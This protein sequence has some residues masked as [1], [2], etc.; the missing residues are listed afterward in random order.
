MQ[1]DRMIQ[2]EKHYTF[3][4]MKYE[5]ISQDVKGR[6]FT[7]V[8]PWLSKLIKTHMKFKKKDTCYND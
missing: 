6:M 2:K 7:S 4:H 1:K 5:L 3:E 8:V